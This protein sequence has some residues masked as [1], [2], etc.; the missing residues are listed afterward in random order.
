MGGTSTWAGG[1]IYFDNG[2]TLSNASGT[3]TATTNVSMFRY[4]STGTA[5]FSNAGTFIKNTGTGAT[6]IGSGI[7]FTNSGTV[8]VQTGTLAVNGLSSSGVVK[9]TGRIS[10]IRFGAARRDHHWRRSVLAVGRFSSPDCDDG[11]RLQHVDDL[12]RRRRRDG[13]RYEHRRRSLIAATNFG[14]DGQSGSLINIVLTNDVTLPEDKTT[15]YTRQLLTYSTLTNLTQAG[16]SGPGGAYVAADNVFNASG[17]TN[18]ISSARIGRFSSAAANV[19]IVFTASP[20]PSRTF[21]CSARPFC[22]WPAM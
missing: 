15:V 13:H 17:L 10:G 11:N 3:F 6:T 19:V 22:S 16:G 4:L 2:S 5:A 1:T 18:F 20:E 9:G 21:S 14:R 7:T 8:D 12:G